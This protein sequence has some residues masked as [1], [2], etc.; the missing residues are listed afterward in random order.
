MINQRR[1]ILFID[2]DF[3]TLSLV[4][5][6]LEKVGHECIC[7]SNGS[8]GLALVIQTK[9]DL[10]L[11][12]YMMP[13]LDGGQVYSELSTNPVYEDYKNTPV[14]ILTAKDS[15]FFL[16]SKFL[17]RGVNA[18]LEKPFGLRELLNVI[19]NVFI[20][21]EIQAKN[22]KLQHEIQQT[23]DYLE[24]LFDTI[25]IGILTC[26]QNGFVKKVNSYF[27]QLFE[28]Y[29][30]DEVLGKNLVKYNLFKNRNVRDR[31]KETL[32]K[33]TLLTI[34]SLNFITNKSS[35]ISVKLKAIPFSGDNT[36]SGCIVIVQDITESERK[37]HELT[38]IGQ[39][40]HFMHGTLQLNQQF[41]LI[42]TA[43]TAG[44][45]LGF[46]RAMILLINKK[47]NMLT[48]RMGI[49][50]A[51]QQEAHRI[52]SELA[53]ED[54]SLSKFIKKYGF[55][56]SKE[57]AFFNDLVQQINVPLSQ[58][59]PVFSEV[60]KKK[61][62]VHVIHDKL[63]AE[64]CTVFP[65][66]L[67][68]KDFIAAPLIA[69]DKVIGVIVADNKFNNQPIE[70]NMAEQL[71]LFS[72]HAG[73]A[74]ERAEAYDEL[75]QK[76]NKLE[77]AYEKLKNT[78]DRLIHSERLATVGKMAAQIT[79]E[80]RNPLVVIGGFA[81][82]IVKL[83]ES[84]PQHE[85]LK[86]NASIIAD[87]VDRLENILSNVLNFSKLSQPEVCLENIN[88]VVSDACLFIKMR[89]E[90]SEKGITIKKKLDN[91]IP[92]TL[93]DPQQVKQVLVNIFENALYSM[94]LGGRLFISTTNINNDNIQIEI[95]DNGEG[96][97]PHILE[98]M[99]NPFFTTKKNG[100]GLGL[101]ISQQIIHSH[102]GKIDVKSKLGQGTVFTITLK[103]I[104]DIDK[105]YQKSEV[106]EFEQI[107]AT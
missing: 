35:R 22:L 8:E 94:L 59:D 44:C 48:G 57:D 32:L 106:S 54:I 56:I 9:P 74:V 69:K 41:H 96:I 100:V 19:E 76:K 21:N 24:L 101:S 29:C 51:N 103:I 25:P 77:K 93:I 31:L 58:L 83:I 86:T 107:S 38:M 27:L 89:D 90:V 52:W 71:V 50:P 15:D 61:A 26:D 47:T 95:R 36:I 6:Y 97:P 42:L 104:D 7:A 40:S 102:N 55:N 87:E 63:A 75:E 49:G 4:K 66:E 85:N 46:S 64:S 70:K 17:E 28:F 81:R 20:I 39:V 65:Y 23:K 2:D 91:T 10:I 53:K 80:V 30:A 3:S 98:E 12:D 88:K 84:N 43:I 72:S 18:Y 105:F 1:K 68:L 13:G 78:Q 5:T 92:L 11:L 99:F 45:A 16:K 60:I 37:Q 82:N 33:G 67:Q 62:P 79:H 14:I 73:L 34:D